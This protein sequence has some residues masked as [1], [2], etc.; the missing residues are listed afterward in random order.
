MKSA[1]SKLRS[2]R[3]NM[4]DVDFMPAGGPAATLAACHFGR[5]RR[6]QSR[7]P[8]ARRTNLEACL[9][10]RVPR[11]VGDPVFARSADGNPS[12]LRALTRPP[13]SRG[14][15]RRKLH[16]ILLDSPRADPT[17]AFRPTPAISM[18]CTKNR[19]D[20]RS[21]NRPGSGRTYSGA[22]ETSKPSHMAA[23]RRPGLPGCHVQ[24][25]AAGDPPDHQRAPRHAWQEG[26]LVSARRL[27]APARS[28]RGAPR[29]R[30]PPP[31]LSPPRLEP[32]P[33][34]VRAHPSH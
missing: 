21:T 20:W 18:T 17:P 19:L 13:P 4:P 8:G 14:T 32:T 16:P 3:V 15:R 5:A 6:A 27:P 26:A 7:N 29:L 25:L 12:A 10:A 28:R 22:H 31:G 2:A 33:R 24:L 11:A 34:A 9:L 1:L 23:A 30:P